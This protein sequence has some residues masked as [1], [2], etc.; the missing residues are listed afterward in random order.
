MRETKGANVWI[1]ETLRVSFRGRGTVTHMP[2]AYDSDIA[3]G[4]INKNGKY[5]K[6]EFQS[7]QFNIHGI[8]I[9]TTNYEI[10][11]LTYDP[12]AKLFEINT[13]DNIREIRK[14]KEFIPHMKVDGSIE[15][16]F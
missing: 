7:N 2:I 6:V 8:H 15:F 16:T 14:L 12:N 9:F 11:Y 10:K 4:W 1:T 5:K 3:Y 13:D